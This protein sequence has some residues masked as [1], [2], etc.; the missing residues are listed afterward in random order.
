M[1]LLLGWEAFA[2]SLPLLFLQRRCFNFASARCCLALPFT[3]RP[4]LHYS[5][6]FLMVIECTGD[7]SC[8]INPA[9]PSQYRDFPRTAPLP[10][11]RKSS[12]HVLCCREMTCVAVYLSKQRVLAVQKRFGSTLLWCEFSSWRWRPPV[13]HL[14]PRRGAPL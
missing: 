14:I 6:N 7:D 11:L 4:A 12:A 8:A 10:R 2:I 3:T 9:Y 1:S 13:L 5:Q